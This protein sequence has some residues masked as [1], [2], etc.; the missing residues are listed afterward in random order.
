MPID[1]NWKRREFLGGA[2]AVLAGGR[3]AGAV[4]GAG[5]APAADAPA[6]AVGPGP[7]LIVR[8]SA[9]EN[10]ESPASAFDS[11]L[12][13]TPS[14]YVRSHFAVPRL[15][16][17][18]WRLKVEGAVRAP[19]EVSLA[20]LRGMPATSKVALLECAGNGRV[21]LVPKA[22]G[23]LWGPGAVGTAEW[24]GVPLRALLERAGVA[25][26]AVEVVLE[27][28][29]SGAV[30]DEP[31]SPGV[32]P[33][34]RSVPLAKALDD[35]LI[36]F[37]MNGR[38]L[39]PAHGF[40]AR[41]VVPGW[42]GM[43]SVK[44]LRRIVVT[45]RPFAGYFQTLEYAT[46]ERAHGLPSLVPLTENAV[47]AQVLRP[48]RGEVVPPGGA[49][50]VRGLAWAGAATVTRVE[51]SADDGATWADARL[52][53]DPVR[54]AWRAWEWTWRA[55]DQAGPHRLLARATD[56]RGRVQPLARDQDLRNY[57]ISHAIP[58]EVVVG[59]PERT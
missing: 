27:G 25:P 10:L 38:D 49:V 29:D 35:V 48:T 54:H 9:P 57:A 59:A 31:R 22:K 12:T 50:V 37:A 43:A 17:A 53:G 19:V 36:A 4:A 34:A 26:G 51:V 46:F 44:W 47:K 55:P 45:N 7:G 28:A 16:A 56:D 2:A 5:A 40:P 58:V 14:F 42:Y 23:L 33:F 52:V 41:A 11:F 15:D 8:E 18:T 30:N 39:T 13:P 20:D 3:A 24:T 21:A 6:P 32:I 1:L